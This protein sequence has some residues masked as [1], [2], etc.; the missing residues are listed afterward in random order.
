MN[1]LLQSNGRNNAIKTLDLWGLSR[2]TSAS[3]IKIAYYLKSLKLLTLFACKISHSS[4]KF[5][6]NECIF[7]QELILKDQAFVDDEILQLIGKQLTQLTFLDC[8][9]CSLISYNGVTELANQLKKTLDYTKTID[10]TG[11]KEII[12]V[13]PLRTRYPTM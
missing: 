5:I 11:C 4:L 6:L 7:I 12:D 2:V 9:E 3:L 1:E 8:S 10:L 13:L